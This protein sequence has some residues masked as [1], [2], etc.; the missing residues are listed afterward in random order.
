MARSSRATVEANKMRLL[1]Y[2]AIQADRRPGAGTSL[3]AI[4]N[5]L[6]LSEGCLRSSC[7]A[8]RNDGLLLVESR[9]DEDGGQK[10]NVYL[11]T[12]KARE[13]LTEL[14]AGGWTCPE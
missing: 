12:L 4:Q 9:F 13:V 1:V 6:G 2:F 11:P 5:D 10:A 7:R 3:K 14:M 8:L